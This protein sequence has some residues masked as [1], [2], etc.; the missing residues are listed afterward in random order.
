M[1]SY[2]KHKNLSKLLINLMLVLVVTFSVMP[3]VAIT[4]ISLSDEVTIA[5]SGYSLLPKGFS[6]EAY[7]FV[8]RNPNETIN[9]YL[10]T[11]IVTVVGT[12][13]SLLCE[14]LIAYPLSRRDFPFKGP[15]S[16]YVFFT[17]LF[18]GGLVPYYIVITQVLR[19][20][21]TLLAMIVPY[22]V[23][24]WDILLLRTFFATIPPSLIESAKLDG[25]S[26]FK[27]FTKIILPLS[28][29]ALVTVG[30]LISI[31]YWNDWWLPL[32]F[33][34]NPKLV[35][36][37]FMLYKIM[38]NISILTEQAKFMN[39]DMGVIPNESARM[40]MCVIAVGPM[41]MVFPF[42]QKYF[43]QGITVGSIK[44]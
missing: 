13:L 1:V 39:I 4:S 36:L 44:G 25:C 34:T 16:F 12:A 9:A 38:T 30:L 18:N 19:L 32:L 24:A 40:A 8:L 27:I 5:T 20:S 3:F 29:S 2:L 41:L 43:V 7:R 11:I 10:V 42:F 22:L 28:K 14:S 21:D 33:I 31:R 26:E 17:M 23:S 15:L 6:L 37:Q 35:N